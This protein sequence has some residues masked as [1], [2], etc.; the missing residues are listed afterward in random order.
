MAWFFAGGSVFG[1]PSQKGSATEVKLRY[2]I[3]LPKQRRMPGD[4]RRAGVAATYSFFF[5]L[6]FFGKTEHLFKMRFESSQYSECSLGGIGVGRLQRHKP[7]FVAVTTG[8]FF[9]ELYSQH[10]YHPVTF[11]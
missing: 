3:G 9:E 2:F 8:G 11:E 4:A 1:F 6:F 7:I 10:Q 5:V